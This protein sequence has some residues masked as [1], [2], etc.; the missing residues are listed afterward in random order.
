VH[1]GFGYPPLVRIHYFV[2]I[3]N[4]ESNKYTVHKRRIGGLGAF[5][6]LESLT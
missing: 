1:H 5:I 3:A 4:N 6:F 2:S